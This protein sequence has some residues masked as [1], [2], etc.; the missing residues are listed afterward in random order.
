MLLLGSDH[1]LR[2]GLAHGLG[3]ALPRQAVSGRQQSVVYGL[4]SHVNIHLESLCVVVVSTPSEKH[5]Y[6]SLG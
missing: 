3:E 5:L 2:G 1:F 6:T 4:S